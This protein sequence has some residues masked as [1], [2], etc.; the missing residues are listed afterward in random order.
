MIGHSNKAAILV[1]SLRKA[2]LIIELTKRG[3]KPLEMSTI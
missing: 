3:S 1:Q 2:E